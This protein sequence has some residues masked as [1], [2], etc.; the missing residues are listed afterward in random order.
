MEYYM[1]MLPTGALFWVTLAYKG[2]YWAD[3]QVDL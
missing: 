2:S 3:P 1:M